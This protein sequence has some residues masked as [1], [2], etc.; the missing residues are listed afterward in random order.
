VGVEMGDVEA[1]AETPTEIG[2]RSEKLEM[3]EDRNEHKLSFAISS[4]I[5]VKLYGL[6]LV[7]VVGYHTVG[8][9][10]AHRLGT[11]HSVSF[12]AR[13]R[14]WGRAGVGRSQSHPSLT[15]LPSRQTASLILT[16]HPHGPHRNNNLFGF[17][18]LA[19]AHRRSDI[20]AP[21][22]RTI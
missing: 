5:V 2:G 4:G 3:I 18:F 22:P 14:P 1:E 17:H 12:D 7:G 20:T 19:I 11:S 10:F 13:R 6:H 16:F 8:I 9:C 15:K 21:L